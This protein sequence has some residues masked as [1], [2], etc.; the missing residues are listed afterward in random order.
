METLKEIEGVSPS[1]EHYSGLCLLLTLNKLSDHPEYRN[2]NPSKGRINCFK[3]VLPLV[4]DLLGGNST[5][6]K[7]SPTSG[8]SML[9]ERSYSYNESVI[10]HFYSNMLF[11]LFQHSNPTF[12]TDP[13]DAQ[14]ATKDRL[15][16]LII[17][18][19]LYESCVD[20]CQQKATGG[21]PKASMNG[22]HTSSLQNIKFTNVLNPSDFSDSDLSLLSW[23]Q[24]M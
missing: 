17:K 20:F 6:D 9:H 4:E 24:V 5:G 2:W 1:K 3:E 13:V 22:S 15:M 23:L 8:E 14:V 11:C 18:G 19:I 16:Q 12:F 10:W 21:P 7:K